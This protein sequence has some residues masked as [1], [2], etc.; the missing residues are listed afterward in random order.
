MKDDMEVL[1][2]LMDER[3]RR[4]EQRFAASEEAVRLAKQ[5]VDS[6]KG[7]VSIIGVVSLI[8]LI[9]TIADKM[10]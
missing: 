6:T 10:R 9:L 1:K 2:E 8:A 3:D 7:T 5:N 4:Y